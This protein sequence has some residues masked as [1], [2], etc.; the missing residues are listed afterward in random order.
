M[1][2]TTRCVPWEAFAFFP[3]EICNGPRFQ[4]C[5]DEAGAARVACDFIL[6]HTIPV[7]ALFFVGKAVKLGNEHRRSAGPGA[8]LEVD[9]EAL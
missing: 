6:L 7:S 1:L 5:V 3:Q 9:D 2:S 8:V 4:Q